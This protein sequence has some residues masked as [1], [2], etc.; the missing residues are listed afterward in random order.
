MHAEISSSH[1]GEYEETGFWD[2]APSSLEKSWPMFQ[3]CCIHHQGA[4]MMEAVC[5]C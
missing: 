4:L 5:T 1:G 2:I 3:R